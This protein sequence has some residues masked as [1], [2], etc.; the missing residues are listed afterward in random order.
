MHIDKLIGAILCG[1][2]RAITGARSLWLGCS[3]VPQQRI[4][5]ANHRSHGDFLL[6]WAALPTDLRQS[7]RPVAGSDYWLKGR[8]RRYLITRVFNAVL[9]DRSGASTEAKPLDTLLAALAQRYSLIFFPEGTRNME[10][11]LLHFKSGLYH[12]AKAFP[13]VELVP[14]WIDNLGRVMPKGS[15]VP[16]PLLCS[17]SFGAP[18]ARIEGE[19]KPA[20]LER[21]AAALQQLSPPQG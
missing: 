2:S 18:L 20:F 19:E 5:Y 21:A 9:V 16:V 10:E 15:Y 1:F 6:I 17:I 14:V 12:M 11:D 13:E 8:L 7:T 4:Y 3:P